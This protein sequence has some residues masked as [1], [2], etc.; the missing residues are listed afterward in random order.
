MLNMLVRANILVL[1]WVVGE[2][3]WTVGFVFFCSCPFVWLRKFCFFFNLRTLSFAFILKETCECWLTQHSLP[4]HLAPWIY[5]PA[6]FWTWLF[7][8]R[9]HLLILLGFPCK[10]RVA[11]LLSRFSV[12]LPSVKC[13]PTV[14]LFMR[15]FLFIL[16][17]VHQASYIS[18]LL[19][20]FFNDLRKFQ[21]VSS[22]IFF[23]SFLALLFFWVS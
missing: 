21:T 15:C 6:A 4:P 16:L 23:C 14:C 2:S 20:F 12:S 11:F 10:W 13:F 18:K 8:L 5:Y 17:G 22:K 1:F 3:L 9:N 7:L 19:L